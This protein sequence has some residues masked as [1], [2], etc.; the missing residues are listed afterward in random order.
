[1]VRVLREFLGDIPRVLVYGNGTGD[2][3]SIGASQDFFLVMDSTSTDR[4]VVHY[5][6]C[7]L[8]AS[9]SGDG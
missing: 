6:D 5:S 2:G 1:M 7:R 9:D 3:H 4:D 8:D